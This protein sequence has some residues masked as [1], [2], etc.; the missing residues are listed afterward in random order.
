MLHSGHCLFFVGLQ[1]LVDT[2]ESRCGIS[3]SGVVLLV[4]LC[5]SSDSLDFLSRAHASSEAVAT[6]YSVDNPSFENELERDGEDAG[7]ICEN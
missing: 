2:V 6:L 4:S 7:V 1:L 3:T 5:E